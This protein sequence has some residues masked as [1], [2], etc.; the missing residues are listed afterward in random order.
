M[1]V[2]A[3]VDWGGWGVHTRVGVHTCVCVHKGGGPQLEGVG[4]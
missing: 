4:T 3:Y 2:R 1:G